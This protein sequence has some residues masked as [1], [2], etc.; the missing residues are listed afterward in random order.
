VTKVSKKSGSNGKVGVKR[1]EYSSPGS[2]S[3]ASWLEAKEA[4]LG[5][6]LVVE[7]MAPAITLRS[8]G[9]LDCMGKPISAAELVLLDFVL[10]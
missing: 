7:P 4:T 10:E 2:N 1:E 5:A 8:A 9:S 3:D 6:R